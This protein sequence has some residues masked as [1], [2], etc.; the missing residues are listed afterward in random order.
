MTGLRTLMP[1]CVDGLLGSRR[2]F[3]FDSLCIFDTFVEFVL[4]NVRNW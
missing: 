3:P 1:F 4:S 2:A